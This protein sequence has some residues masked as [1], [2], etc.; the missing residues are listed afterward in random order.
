MVLRVPLLSASCGRQSSKMNPTLPKNN[1][2]LFASGY[3]PTKRTTPGQTLF[4][5][6]PSQNGQSPLNETMAHPVLATST[7]QSVG[8][9]TMGGPVNFNYPSAN[10]TTS[11]KVSSTTLSNSNKIDQV[12]QNQ[13]TLDQVSQKGIST[14]PNGNAMNANGTQAKVAT[15]TMQNADGSTTT[16]YSDGTTSQTAPN[17]SGQPNPTGDQQGYTSAN[18]SVEDTA[19]KNIIDHLIAMSDANTAS[20]IQS[21]QGQ[22]AIREQQQS[23]LNQA[24]QKATNNA[25]LMGGVTG[26]GSSA[27]F[28]PISSQGI[29]QAQ[30]SYGI[31]QL[32]ALDAQENSDI[33][34]AR[35]AGF[36]ND[37]QLQSKILDNIN[38]TRTAKVNLASKIND[39]VIA[40]NQK[41]ADQ[42]LQANTDNAI[43]DV[44]SQGIKDAPSIMAKLKEQGI[45][46]TSD[47]VA[48]ALKNTGIDDIN[49]IA[50][51]ASGN[52][53]PLSVLNAIANAKTAQEA[54]AAAGKWSRD[55]LDV[56]LKQAQ[57]ANVY[58]EINQRN[59]SSNENGTLNGKPQTATQSTAQ[60]Y[61][62]RMAQANATLD[63]LGGQFTGKLSQIGVVPNFLRSSDR[64]V[65]DQAKTNF[66]TAVLRRESGAAI[67][68]SEFD[69]ADKQYFPQPGDDPAV[70]AAKTATRNTAINN[71]YREANLPRPTLPGDIIQS[72]G[73]NYQVGEDGVTLTEVK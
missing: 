58:S 16:T 1:S 60:S 56:A 35:Q 71:F 46:V 37:F 45:S 13:Q 65:F 52:G 68:N 47:Q 7:N 24:S 32:A 43:S 41:I 51:E 59:Y 12:N 55:P 70:V 69:T 23:I 18:T 29:V 28:A 25:L 5:I 48:N 57:I 72:K 61:A 36:N 73:K 53:A 15:G 11:N 39:S 62:N 10:N 26:Q 27:Q 3:D 38:Q 4:N 9:S 6:A 20:T 54:I 49:K 63:T 34:A 67:S 8:T 44:Y 19:T 33:S 42:I 31:Q 64:Q 66:V 40:Q 21:I 17:N 50:A 22:Y 14:D 2:S 30:E